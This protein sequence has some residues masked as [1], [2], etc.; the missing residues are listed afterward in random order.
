MSHAKNEEWKRHYKSQ[1]ISRENKELEKKTKA[2]ELEVD[3]LKTGKEKPRKGDELL[4]DIKGF[5]LLGFKVSCNVSPEICF[6]RTSRRY[7]KWISR[8]FWWLDQSDLILLTYKHF[9]YIVLLD[10]SCM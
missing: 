6:S 10:V 2:L 1:V 9:H 8:T 5:V 3:S 4:T 7:P